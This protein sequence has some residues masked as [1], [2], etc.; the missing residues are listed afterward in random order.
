MA[1][2]ESYMQKL[3]TKKEPATLTVLPV[4]EAAHEHSDSCGCHDEGSCGCSDE[5]CCGG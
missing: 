4:L 3:V 5:G 2:M 1:P